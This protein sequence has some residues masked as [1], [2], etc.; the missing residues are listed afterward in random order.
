MRF[1]YPQF[2][3]SKALAMVVS[4]TLCLASCKKPGTRSEDDPESTK[5]PTATPPRAIEPPAKTES[6]PSS[7]SSTPTSGMKHLPPQKV[8]GET[9]SKPIKEN[10]PQKRNPSL[11]ELAVENP[12]KVSL[13]VDRQITN[14]SGNTLDVTITA[15]YEKEI[16]V[17]RKSDSKAFILPIGKL[18][19]DDSAFALTLPVSKKPEPADPFVVNRQKLIEGHQNEILRLQ[20]KLVSGTLNTSQMRANVKREKDLEEKIAELKKQIQERQ[21]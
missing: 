14:S 8:A 15:R 9:N 5:A 16:A 20:Q 17:V 12:V 2:S 10:P 18:S 6:P 4:A 13:P 1:P 21:Q 3:S 7:S 11:T 19:D